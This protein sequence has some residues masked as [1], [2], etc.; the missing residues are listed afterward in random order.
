MFADAVLD[1][2]KGGAAV[3]FIQDYH[4]A[5]LPRMLKRRNPK[6]AIAQFWH[7]PWPNRETLRAFPWKEEL[8]DGLL[9]NDVLGFHVGQH[10]SNFL[11]TLDRTMEALVDTDRSS[12]TRGGHVTNVRPFPI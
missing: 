5:L 2:S 3:V 10:C 9:G 4:L 7:I 1:E 8:L 11:D 12:V 6:L